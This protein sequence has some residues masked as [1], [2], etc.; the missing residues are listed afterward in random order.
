MATGELKR[1]QLEEL[2]MPKYA[3]GDAVEND[4]NETGVVVA[5]FTTDDGQPR[6]VMESDGAL[7]F[8]LENRLA[9][10][11]TKH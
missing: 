3:L 4:A 9:A 7:Q 8:V 6:Y 10:R 1:A 11:E 2:F 5:I